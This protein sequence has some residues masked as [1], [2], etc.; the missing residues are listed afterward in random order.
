[1]RAAMTLLALGAAALLAA[2]TEPSQEPAK[3]YAG[4]EDAKAYSGDAFKGDKEKWEKKLANR[5]QLQNEYNRA[6]ALQANR[7]PQ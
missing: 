2:C 4:K 6:A 7:A 3:T 5:A 1:M